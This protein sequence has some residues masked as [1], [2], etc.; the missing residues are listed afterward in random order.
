M[1]LSPA[2]GADAALD[3]D[4]LAAGPAAYI[5]TSL[6]LERHGPTRAPG[7]PLERRRAPP[8]RAR[9]TPG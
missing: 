8:E 7:K 1:R 5:G 4:W 3:V 2:N 9:R 6:G